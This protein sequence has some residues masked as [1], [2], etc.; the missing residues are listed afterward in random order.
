M[1]SATS[2]TSRSEQVAQLKELFSGLHKKM[3]RLDHKLDHVLSEVQQLKGTLGKMDN[4]ID[5]VEDVYTK[6]RHPLN[7][8]KSKFD[9]ITGNSSSSSQP[10]PLLRDSAAVLRLD[11]D[12]TEAERSDD[13]EDAEFS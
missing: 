2:T 12:A 1:A 4:H 5:F 10:L 7:Y 8:I 3:D 11:D 13:G 6:V 9:A